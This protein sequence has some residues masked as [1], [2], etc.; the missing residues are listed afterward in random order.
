MESGDVDAAI[1]ALF[2]PWD[3]PGSPGCALAVAQNGKSLYSRGY[4]YA[5]LDHNVPVTP[6]TVFDVGSLTKQFIAA[7]ITMME[8]EGQLS[9][10]DSVRRWLPELHE[11]NQPITLR[12]MIYHT[13]GLRDYLTLFPLAGRG[14]YYPISHAQILDMMSRQRALV[15]APGERYL[16]SNTA[17]MLLAL[18]IER[19]SGQTPGE[20]VNE[21]IFAPLAMQDSLMYDDRERIIARRATGY[22][23][24]DASDLRVVHNFNFDVPGDGQMYTT[25]LDLLRWDDYLHGATKPAIHA[26][27]LAEGALNDGAPIARARGL[28]LGEYRGLRT[29]Q[30]TGSSWGFRAALV[31][32]V[33]PELA[34]A[35]AC[36]DGLAN[37]LQLA[38]RIA[39][40]LLEDE[41]EPKTDDERRSDNSGASEESSRPVVSPE[42]L[43]EFSGSYYSAELDAIYRFAIV[44]DGLS[45]RIE[46]EAPLRVLP[47]ADDQFTISFDEQAYSGI[48]HA[49][50]SFDRGAG[51]DVSGF[52]LSSGTERDIAFER[53]DFPEA[54]R[55]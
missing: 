21:H 5:D 7:S 45:V 28:F 41:L 32:Y 20:F 42:R 22:D 26:P 31:R 13:G 39:D 8:Q 52:R 2:A 23:R 44:D 19:A 40:H 9:L 34:I 30:H 37:P 50:L 49:E 47:A 27:M 12:H 14:H 46:Q 11:L 38:H 29:V 17:Y 4:G 18:V 10:D 6:G 48:L 25:V 36:N 1:D 24:H 33:E 16:Y 51:G 54:G 15:F 53:L 55:P 35:I 3:Q 43:N